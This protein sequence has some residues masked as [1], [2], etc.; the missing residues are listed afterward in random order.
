METLFPPPPSTRKCYGCQA[1]VT[2]PSSKVWIAS[3]PV[4]VNPNRYSFFQTQRTIYRTTENEFSPQT[5]IVRFRRITGIS[6]WAKNNGSDSRT[7]D[8]QYPSRLDWNILVFSFWYPFRRAPQ[9]RP[10]NSVYSKA[11]RL[12]AK[13]RYEHQMERGNDNKFLVIWN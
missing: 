3:F 1:F 5:C 2:P 6:A 7:G 13:T 12:K 11:E 4:S 9:D 10:R 8:F